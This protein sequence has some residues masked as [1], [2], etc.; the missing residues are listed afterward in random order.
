M[1]APPPSAEAACRRRGGYVARAAFL[2]AVPLLPGAGGASAEPPLRLSAMVVALERGILCASAEGGRMAA[3]DTEHG[4][5]HVPDEPVTLRRRGAL[6]PAVL[7][8]G[9]GV[10]YTLAGSEPVLIRYVIEHPPL[11]PSGRQRQSWES[12][13]IGGAP[14]IVFFQFDHEA[15]LLPGRWSFAGLAGEEEVFF[16]AFDI[17][18]PAAAPHLAGLCTGE[19][20]ITLSR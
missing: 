19:E 11:P 4:W 17:V 20:Q 18:P 1:S 9:F 13:V 14:E 2:L 16:A 8:L 7:G 6:V 12:W 3:P 10:D 5:I 15:E